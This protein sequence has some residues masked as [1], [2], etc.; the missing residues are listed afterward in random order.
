METLRYNYKN[1]NL[2]SVGSL[3]E[4]INTG[5]VGEVKRRGTNYLIC[6]TEDGIMFKSWLQ[7]VRTFTED[8]YEVGTDK[9][10]KF[11]Q[12]LTPGQPIVSYTKTNIR[13]TIPKS[14][15]KIRKEL[16]KVGRR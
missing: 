16:S 14:I 13:E 15:N 11:L 9:Y 2:Y 5:L 6:I 4:N 8:V 7:N 3:V 1:N 12:R 10:R